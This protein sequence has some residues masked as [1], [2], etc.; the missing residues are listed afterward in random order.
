MKRILIVF[1]KELID[2]LR[3]RRTLLT[4]VLT[5]LMGP[6]LLAI[7][8]TLQVQMLTEDTERPLAIPIVGANYAPGLVQFLQQAGIKTLP[9]PRDPKEVVRSGAY[10]V[11]LVI[12]PDYPEQFR[13]GRPATVQLVVDKAR[14]SARPE[15]SRTENLLSAYARQITALRLLARGVDP[16]L[17]NPVTIETEDVAT[18]Q[19]RAAFILGTM[20][21]FII[22]SV[23]L[24]GLYVAIDTTTG[25][26]ERGSLEPLVINPVARW[27]LVAGK[28]LTTLLFTLVGAA[29]TIV[30]LALLLRLVP[31]E[32]L[33][34]ELSLT[35]GNFLTM[36][37]LIVPVAL[38][39]SASQMVVATF[40]RSF[41]EAQNYVTPLI[42]IPTLPGIFLGFITIKGELWQMLIPVF[43][44]Q[45]L[46]N[47][48]IRGEVLSWSAVLPNALS[49]LA[50]G[51][52]LT[53]GAMRLFERAEI[54][55]GR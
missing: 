52:A 1:Q 20:P 42:L 38:I 9:A 46:I 50:V 47:Q 17:I 11:V 19:G 10:E 51:M 27:Q 14:Q 35:L 32:R 24:G 15:I 49:T 53:W 28:L 16:G 18:A 25:E 21:Y 41:K 44:Q 23:F 31:I 37:L 13:A 55:A 45:I 3:D 36:Y 33:G 40:T 7:I 54:V 5:P 29:E 22:F 48:L 2:N 39:A 30:A 26:R 4:A 8:L 6:V 43:G 12:P 34:L